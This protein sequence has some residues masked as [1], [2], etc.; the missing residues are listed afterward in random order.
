[1]QHEYGIHKVL[2]QVLIDVSAN[3]MRSV[4][5]A[6]KEKK[7]IFKIYIYIYIYIYIL[8]MTLLKR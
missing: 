7:R 1:M 3:Y 8:P 4:L 5:Q 6:R 2:S